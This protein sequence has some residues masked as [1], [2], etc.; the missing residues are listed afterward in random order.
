M[1]KC[2]VLAPTKFFCRAFGAAARQ[3]R[4]MAL[5]QRRSERHDLR[6]GTL[7]EGSRRGS[8]RG[9]SWCGWNGRREDGG[10]GTGRDGRGR[11]RL[12]LRLRIAALLARRVAWARR[13]SDGRARPRG[14]Q[15]LRL[16]RLARRGGGR[17]SLSPWAGQGRG[18]A[19]NHLFHKEPKFSMRKGS[20]YSLSFDF[21]PSHLW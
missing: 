6:A 5:R 14:G 16:G 19:R 8:R 21:L 7:R 20:L 9:C 12:G 17:V 10:G 3:G 2:P 4:W 13:L 15:L 18:W 1:E 11:E